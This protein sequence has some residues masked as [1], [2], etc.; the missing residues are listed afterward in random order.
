MNHLLVLYSHFRQLV[1]TI[2]ALHLMTWHSF[3]V[4]LVWQN[5]TYES[6]LFCCVLVTVE[7]WLSS[8]SPPP[9]PSP[10]PIGPWWFLIEFFLKVDL[11]D[12]RLLWSFLWSTL[13]WS[14]IF[15]SQ[16]HCAKRHSPGNQLL[17]MSQR[18]QRAFQTSDQ[19]FVA[20]LRLS[21]V[22]K[23]PTRHQFLQEAK[24]ME[25]ANRGLNKHLFLLIPADLYPTSCYRQQKK[26]CG[27]TAFW[28][29][30]LD[31]VL[32]QRSKG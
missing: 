16:K 4:V 14:Q 12:L 26:C 17:V 27:W 29:R 5:C 24:K 25:A 6:F 23:S 20:P 9:P 15:P 18:D 30:V 11:R 32:C 7:L 21:F 10:P 13:S 22:L 1:T 3:N 28:H 8:T 19:V 2:C 31:T